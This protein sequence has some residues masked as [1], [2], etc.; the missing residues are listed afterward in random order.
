MVAASRSFGIGDVYRR[1][2]A[3][4]DF[5]HM[6]AIAQFE[7]PRGVIDLLDHALKVDTLAKGGVSIGG[8]A[9]GSR[10]RCGWRRSGCLLRQHNSD[11]LGEH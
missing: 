2:R 8:S 11:G 3:R 1:H 6:R 5:I 10:G 9:F 4:F 7:T